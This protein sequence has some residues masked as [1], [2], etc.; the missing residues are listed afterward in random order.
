MSRTGGK[1]RPV[2]GGVSY[3]FVYMV[4]NVQV[5]DMDTD[6]LIAEYETDLGDSSKRRVFAEQM[7]EAY[8]NNQYSIVEPVRVQRRVF[9]KDAK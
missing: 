1:C 6:A 5:R 8:A 7:N 4:L 3:P 9:N 2:D